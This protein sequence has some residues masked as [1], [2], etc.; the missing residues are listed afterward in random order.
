MTSDDLFLGQLGF[1]FGST[2][3]RKLPL[4]WGQLMVF[5]EYY[6]ERS[7]NIRLWYYGLPYYPF[8]PIKLSRLDSTWQIR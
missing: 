6:K 5:P 8:I 1:E 2:P 7:L 3:V 4:T